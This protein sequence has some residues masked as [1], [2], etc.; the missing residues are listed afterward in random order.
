MYD[1]FKLC[2]TL[3]RCRMPVLSTTSSWFSTPVP[4]L[5]LSTGSFSIPVPVSTP[6]HFTL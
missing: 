2:A 6:S 3:R 5:C 4:I 1:I